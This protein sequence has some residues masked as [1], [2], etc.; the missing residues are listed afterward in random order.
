MKFLYNIVEWLRSE[1]Y[2]VEKNEAIVPILRINNRL[3]IKDF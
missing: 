3:L 1:M 2:R